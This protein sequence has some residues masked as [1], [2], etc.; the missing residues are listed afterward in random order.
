M[1]ISPH[2]SHHLRSHH[3]SSY[4]PFAPDLELISFTN[5]FLHSL[6]DTIRYDTIEEFNVDSKAECDQLILAHETKNK[7]NFDLYWTIWVL[8]FVC[9]RFFF[10]Y[11]CNMATRARLRWS[12]SAFGYTLNTLSTTNMKWHMANRIGS[13]SEYMVTWPMM[14]RDPE[15][16]KS[17]LVNNIVGYSS[18]R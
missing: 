14:S 16:S 2:H 9:F 7:R 5:P 12:H 17:W 15:R 3:L 18:G 13:H 4:W 6:S 11:F 10:L 1:R 8:A